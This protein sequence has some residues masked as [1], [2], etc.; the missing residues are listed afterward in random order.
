MDTY[1]VA[2]FVGAFG[3]VIFLVSV[4]HG[5]R[6]YKGRVRSKKRMAHAVAVQ[7]FEDIFGISPYHENSNEVK[8]RVNNAMVRLASL[9]L[10]A[11]HHPE[12]FACREAHV[13][14]SS[15]AIAFGFRHMN[16][17]RPRQT[18]TAAETVKIDKDHLP[19]RV[20]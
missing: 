14:A 9:R 7:R 1:A 3:L 10:R 17:P 6:F 5:F 8:Q 2:K 13:Q 20:A 11:L 16:R 4:L 19:D 18:H 12:Y 15:L